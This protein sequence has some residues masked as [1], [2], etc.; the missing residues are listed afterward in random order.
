MRATFIFLFFALTGFGARTQAVTGVVRDIDT[1]TPL[2]YVAVFW[3]ES[4]AGTM[5]N[6]EGRFTIGRIP[7]HGILVFQLIP[8]NPLEV[9]ISE[10]SEYL[11]ELKIN[12]MERL[13]IEEHAGSQH[14]HGK[15]PHLFQTMT[16][17]ELC[18]AACCNLSESF[19]TNASVDASYTDGISGTRQIKMLGL[20]GKYAQLMSDNIPDLRG[21]ATV[22][23]L[24][25]EPGPWIKEINISKG[26]GSIIPGYE[27]IAG[28][29]NV[30]H[31]ADEM[32]ER[33]FLNGYA[34]NQGRYEWNTV[35]QHSV[36]EH[37]NW[38]WSS[39]LALNNG[40]FDMNHDGFL[41]N[42]TGREFNGRLHASY[43]GH[44]GYRG[45]YTVTALNYG[46]R[47][48]TYGGHFWAPLEMKNSHER[49]GVYLKN[50]WV[51]EREKEQS[52][53][54]Q[55][56]FTDYHMG[57]Q[58][59][60]LPFESNVY[61]GHQRNLRAVAMHAMEWTHDIKWTNGL[62]WNWDEYR[63]RF[64]QWGDFNRKENVIG[65]FSELSWNEDDKFQAIVGARYDYHNYFGS[66]VTPRVHFRYSLKENVHVKMMMG[67]GR[68]VVNPILDN[69]GVLASNR[70]VQMTV[71]DN[72]Y[73]N[74]LPME[75]AWNSG[76]VLSGDTKLFYRKMTWSLDVFH[77]RFDQQV[78]MD[79][80]SVGYL[81]LYSLNTKDGAQSV[82]QT[83]QFEAQLSPLKRMEIRMAY[84][85]VNTFVD[86][87]TGRRSL[88]FISRNKIYTN[89]SYSTKM[90]GN[91]NRVM[92]D[93]T[94]K[95]SDRQRMPLH[96]DDGLFGVGN[97]SPAF[98]MINAQVSLA[99]E[100]NWD[101]YLGVENLLNYQQNRVVTYSQPESLN[102]VFDSNFA[103]APA[104]GRM[105]YLGFRLR[106]GG[107]KN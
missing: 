12:E 40:E 41:D 47:F 95:W 16:E 38:D 76:I 79:W 103:Y 101:I 88:P 33:F 106:L 53:G 36:G 26:A 84:R 59:A 64:Y 66:L 31:K 75:S 63:E 11:V 22:Y 32:K 68:R 92:M 71:S 82:S 6:A 91:K 30:S 9:A 73:P 57:F 80:D 72:Q 23:G 97:F 86:Y 44:E 14:L 105:M 4:Q 10:Q 83:A 35:S 19:E 99:K 45:D 34:G 18:K 27:S 51:L 50:G 46:S 62:S 107:E 20:D 78:V 104:F 49:Y 93:V 54:T 8:Y 70:M 77:T 56:S 90:F 85:Y 48:G 1:G 74:G 17:K 43:E 67:K 52:I 13:E 21:L 29:I 3:K 69:P 37:F 89:L 58:Q 81:K 55:L 60:G 25:W 94:A 2:E 98:W 96:P 39:H 87:E 28:Q 65:A 42:P 61:S 102:P 7:N 100:E 24:G 15:D 5:T